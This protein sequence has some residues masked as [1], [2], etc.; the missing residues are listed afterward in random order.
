[1]AGEP[2]SARKTLM[3]SQATIGLQATVPY[4]DFNAGRRA[5]LQ[6]FLVEEGQALS[7]DPSPVS[8]GHN[9]SP[10]HEAIGMPT[11][12][13]NAIVRRSIECGLRTPLADC[14]QM[15]NLR[16]SASF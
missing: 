1:L 9:A 3:G 11:L 4:R 13:Q 5:A 14:A 2:I 8:H 6:H 12:R 7:D 10:L 16:S 15:R